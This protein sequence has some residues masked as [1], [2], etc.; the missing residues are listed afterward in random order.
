MT[1]ILLIA[2]DTVRALL[3]QQGHVLHPVGV[4]WVLDNECNGI[5]GRL[6]LAIGMVGQNLFNIAFHHVFYPK[7]V[8]RQL[9]FKDGC[10]AHGGK[11]SDLVGKTERRSVAITS[12]SYSCK[13]LP[14][15][16]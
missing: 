4:V 3:H 10:C 9:Q 16:H 15:S 6:L 8:G 2:R 13:L 14:N 1:T 5:A 11:V 12:A 7:R